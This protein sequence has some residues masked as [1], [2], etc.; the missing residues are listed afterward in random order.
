[1]INKYSFRIAG[2]IQVIQIFVGVTAEESPST[3]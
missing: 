3:Q 1:M 2:I